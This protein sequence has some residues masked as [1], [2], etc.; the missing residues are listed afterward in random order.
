M[1]IIDGGSGPIGAGGDKEDVEG[2]MAERHCLRKQ[3][4]NCSIPKAQIP[5][6]RLI[7]NVLLII[8]CSAYTHFMRAKRFHQITLARIMHAKQQRSDD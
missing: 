3:L 8:F 2:R 6:E 4:S 7:M 5:G 1:H